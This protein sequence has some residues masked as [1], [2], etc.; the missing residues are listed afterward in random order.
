MKFCLP[1]HISTITRTK[2]MHKALVRLV[3]IIYIIH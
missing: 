2:H 3:I 1:P